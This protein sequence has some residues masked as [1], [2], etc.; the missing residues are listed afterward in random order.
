M[1]QQSLSFS[2]HEISGSK[3][4]SRL[5]YLD[6]QCWNRSKSQE[7]AK[8]EGIDLN[9]DH[10]AVISFLRSHYLWNGEQWLVNDHGAT[11]GGFPVFDFVETVMRPDVLENIWK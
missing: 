1:N 7:L 11:R 4:S 3:F 6:A 9:D 8:L 10:W 2:D 5:S